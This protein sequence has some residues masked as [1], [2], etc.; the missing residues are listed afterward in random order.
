MKKTLLTALTFLTI[1]VTYFYIPFNIHSSTP[2]NISAARAA[3]TEGY[4]SYA[5]CDQGVNNV[6]IQTGTVMGKFK[7][8]SLKIQD[9]AKKITISYSVGGATK[10]KPYTQTSN[11]GMILY[12]SADTP[13]SYVMLFADRSAG[14]NAG[15]VFISNE[16][17]FK[18]IHPEFYSFT[19]LGEYGE[20]MEEFNKSLDSRINDTTCKIFNNGELTGFSMKAGTEGATPTAPTMTLAGSSDPKRDPMTFKLTKTLKV[21]GV[22]DSNRLLFYFTYNGSEAKYSNIALRV[23]SDRVGY[24]LAYGD[25]ENYTDDGDTQSSPSFTSGYAKLI[26]EGERLQQ[27][28]DF[29]YNKIYNKKGTGGTD[30]G[31]VVGPG[32]TLLHKADWPTSG[33]P[34]WSCLNQSA[35]G[36]LEAWGA[37]VVERS[38]SNVDGTVSDECTNDM[39]AVWKDPF[40]YAGCKIAAFFRDMASSIM[41]FAEIKLFDSL[42]M[43]DMSTMS[44]ST[45]K[46][47]D[48]NAIQNNLDRKNPSPST[49]PTPTTGAGS[50][51]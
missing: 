12:T 42:G 49:T 50:T 2:S 25:I 38:I 27:L 15:T 4:N 31:T 5:T 1:F 51:P 35:T 9:G 3:A 46:S 18:G 45:C 28:F 34:N 39:L 26:F 48:A 13:A 23:H 19:S 41:C 32:D 6:L 7:F 30:C 14:A 24:A 11:G 17:I 36:Y 43:L 44:T 16:K 8:G 22:G 37:K 10:S 47:G 29:L 20:F 33:E 21:G 40:R